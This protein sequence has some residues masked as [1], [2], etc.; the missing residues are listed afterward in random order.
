MFAKLRKLGV[1][2]GSSSKSDGDELPGFYTFQSHFG[3]MSLHNTDCLR[4]I[5]FPD[6][7][8]PSVRKV[9]QQSWPGGVRSEKLYGGSYEFRMHG[10]P[11]YGK[12]NEGIAAR[13]MM[14]NL[15]AT[16]CSL[17]WVM[18]ISTDLSKKTEDKDSLIFR[19]QSPPP[20]AC[21]WM[22]VSFSNWG[23]IR[24]YDAPNELITSLARDLAPVLSSKTA[25][26]HSPGVAELRCVGTPWYAHG[27]ATMMS[28]Q[29]ALQMVMTLEQHGFTVY[30]SIDQKLN[31]DDRRQGHFT[32]SETDTWHV[33]RTVDWRPGMPV[34]HK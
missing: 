16:L 25:Y 27:K 4:L 9:I 33:C 20:P 19:H 23:T 31:V 8:L 21:E 7:V 22:S 24:L 6:A 30:A 26:Q 13:R 17:G 5:G 29:I 15:L 32:F 11:W 34:F 1:D 12:G 18:T 3:S 28:R 2:S 10:Y 14:R